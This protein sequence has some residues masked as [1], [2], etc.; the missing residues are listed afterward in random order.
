MDFE[1][2]RSTFHESLPANQRIDPNS[3]VC[4]RS[5]AFGVKI[6]KPALRVSRTTRS[7]RLLQF[8]LF[9]SEV[10]SSP[11]EV[12]EFSCRTEGIVAMSV[13]DAMGVCR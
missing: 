6:V 2:K 5:R 9:T 13:S 8:Q 12:K 4:Q 7:I 1:W 11:V 3:K 10:G